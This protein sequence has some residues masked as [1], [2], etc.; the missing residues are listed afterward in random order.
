[1]SY[2]NLLNI[3]TIHYSAYKRNYVFVVTTK[4]EQVDIFGNSIK[5]FDIFS[6]R[7]RISSGKKMSK[8]QLNVLENSFRYNLFHYLSDNLHNLFPLLFK[9]SYT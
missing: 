4:C 5:N 8:L 3:V 7:R 6:R 9:C 2:R 1:M